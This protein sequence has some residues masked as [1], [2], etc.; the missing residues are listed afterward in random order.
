M[1]METANNLVVVLP[2]WVVFGRVHY[3]WPTA[4][5]KSDLPVASTEEDSQLGALA[6]EANHPDYCFSC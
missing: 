4:K 5:A 3:E 6:P 1:L 2:V